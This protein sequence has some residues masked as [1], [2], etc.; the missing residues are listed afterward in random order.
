MPSISSIAP[1][2]SS[3]IIIRGWYNMPVMASVIVASVALHAKKRKMY[4]YYD[5]IKKLT[6]FN[7]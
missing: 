1:Y 7:I 3:S 5:E 6:Y 4:M 2:S